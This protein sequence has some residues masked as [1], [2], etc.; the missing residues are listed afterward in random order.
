L[1]I[2]LFKRGLPYPLFS[3]ERNAPIGKARDGGILYWRAFIPEN[4]IG[5][6][7][8]FHKG[9]EREGA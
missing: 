9:R 2:L 3:K 4:N 6:I 7:D 8:T 1:V 5:Q